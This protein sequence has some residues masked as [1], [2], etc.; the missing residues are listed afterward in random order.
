MK[1]INNQTVN[2]TKNGYVYINKTKINSRPIDPFYSA[3][4]VIND[5]Q[6]HDYVKSVISRRW[7]MINS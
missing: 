4:D 3:N 2:V 6:V 5:P 1:K 7:R